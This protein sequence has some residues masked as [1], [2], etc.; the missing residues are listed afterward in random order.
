MIEGDILYIEEDGDLISVLFNGTYKDK[1]SVVY[2]HGP[3][4]GHSEFIKEEDIIT[5]L[6]KWHDEKERVELNLKIKQKVLSLD[7]DLI[8][9]RAL[10][11]FLKIC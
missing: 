4:K 11:K 2:Q 9:A 8:T 1:L 3:R 7:C 10:A 5:D 6:S